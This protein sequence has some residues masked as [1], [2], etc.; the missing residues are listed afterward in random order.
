MEFHAKAFEIFYHRKNHGFILIVLG[1]AQ[2]RKVGQTADMMDIAL[3]IQLHFQ[4]AVP[5]F[6]SEHGAPVQPKVG[7]QHFVIEHIGNALVV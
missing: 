1:K 7:I 3:D 6:K 2:C 4:R 5:V